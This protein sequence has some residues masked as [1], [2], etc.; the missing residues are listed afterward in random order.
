[1]LCVA[2]PCGCAENVIITAKFHYKLFLMPYFRD[3]G[4][5]NH[6]RVV[7]CVGRLVSVKE[8]AIPWYERWM[9]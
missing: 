3:W 9:N 4:V 2:L 1:M 6:P 7:H 5:L 8:N